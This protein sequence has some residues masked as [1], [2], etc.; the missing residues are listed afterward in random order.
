MGEGG[1]EVNRGDKREEGLEKERIEEMGGVEREKNRGGRGRIGQ[2]TGR[3]TKHP[4]VY[5]TS[6][7]GRA[8]IRF[9]FSGN[10]NT[11]NKENPRK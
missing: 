10:C 9:K 7:S 5:A 8:P 3:H 4:C 1:E 11:E 2:E 6:T